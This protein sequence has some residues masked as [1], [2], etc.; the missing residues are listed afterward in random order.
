ML[1]TCEGATIRF[2]LQVLFG[3]QHVLLHPK[4]I[5]SSL[6]AS[7]LRLVGWERYPSRTFGSCASGGWCWC[8]GC[9]G[10]VDHIVPPDMVPPD[11]APPEICAP[12]RVLRSPYRSRHWRSSSVKQCS[13]CA[14]ADEVF[15]G[16]LLL[17]D[18]A[19]AATCQISQKAGSCCYEWRVHESASKSSWH[20]AC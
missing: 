2:Q 11:M 14:Q 8:C 4:V 10:L 13:F 9:A 12:D 1:L 20:H 3:Q 7:Q 5:N 15:S 16:E 17:V 6:H 18:S 19:H